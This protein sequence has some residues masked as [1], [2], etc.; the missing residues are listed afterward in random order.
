MQNITRKDYAALVK[1]TSPGTKGVKATVNAYVVGGLICTIGHAFINLYNNLGLAKDAA[2]VAASLTLVFIA[3]LLTGFNI[4]DKIAKIG[5]AG[6][7]IP[8]TGFANAVTAPAMD[9]K[10]EGYVLGLGAKMFSIAGPVIVYGIVFYMF[11]LD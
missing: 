5:G 11:G 8:I 9:Y 3:A 1:K 7:L 4:F 2:S 6:T 10:S